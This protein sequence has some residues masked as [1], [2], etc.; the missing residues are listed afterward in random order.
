MSLRCWTATVLRRCDIDHILRAAASLTNHPRFVVVGTG[1]VIITARHIPAS[2]MMTEEID[3][4]AEDV[5]DSQ[6]L[7]DLIDGT[8]GHGSLFHR[9][10]RYY[11]DGVSPE[12]AIMPPDWRSRATEYGTPDG[13]ATAI[14]PS[15]DDIAVAK[16]C[17]W[18]DKD[19]TWLREA[20]ESGLVDHRRL[21]ALTT[22]R[23]PDAA[24]ELMERQ[25]RVRSLAPSEAEC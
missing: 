5:A 8:I 2:M 16:L 17:A 4:Y 22:A 24:P 11:G 23:L 3:L 15:P 20:I 10:F 14:C 1:A 12:T 21:A 19:Q 7:S 6:L 13:S 18:R 25:R 9:T